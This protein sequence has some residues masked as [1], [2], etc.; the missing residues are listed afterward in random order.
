[1]NWETYEKEVY[2][3][4]P[5]E[6]KIKVQTDP[7]NAVFC[8]DGIIDE[9]VFGKA[10][11]KGSPFRPLYILKEF[12]DEG[13]CTNCEELLN[14]CKSHGINEATGLHWIDISKCN[15]CYRKKERTTKRLLYIAKTLEDVL[16]VNSNKEEDI[17]NRVAI[18]NL[19]KMSGGSSIGTEKSVSTLDFSCHAQKFKHELKAQ[20]EG[21]QPTIIVCGSTCDDV[22]KILDNPE[23][24]DTHNDPCKL[25]K[26][27]LLG[28]DIYVL[29]MYHPNQ[30]RVSDEV[31]KEL[32]NSVCEKIKN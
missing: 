17:L 3:F 6:A 22:L 32:I 27:S 15:L 7:E 16:G 8:R 10:Q 5:N 24:I 4:L 13:G 19:K 14:G 11:L 23:E 28:K 1:M 30:S 9:S 25:Y 26:A 12:H 2:D 31:L 29:G 20:I 21:I 18:I